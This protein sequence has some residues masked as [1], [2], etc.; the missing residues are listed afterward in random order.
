MYK[1][2]HTY[3]DVSI[4][5]LEEGL[6]KTQV[7]IVFL[8]SFVMVAFLSVVLSTGK[9]SLLTTNAKNLEE[10]AEA[11]KTYNPLTNEIS[12]NAYV[13]LNLGVKEIDKTAKERSFL[14][15]GNEEK[16]FNF[17][18]P[19]TG[20]TFYTQQFMPGDGTL[21][22]LPAMLTNFIFGSNY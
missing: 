15:F 20:E 18:E 1:N 14:V 19:K 5:M 8:T 22:K 6:G 2:F 21:V 12:V 4:T 3:D 7:S 11:Q 17:T 16:G 9:I 13:P 10:K